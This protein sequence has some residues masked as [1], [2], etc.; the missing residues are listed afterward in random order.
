MKKSDVIQKYLMD[1]HIESI[2][3]QSINKV[4]AGLAQRQKRNRQSVDGTFPGPCGA[5]AP[6]Q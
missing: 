6:E 4:L 2:T 5:L 3:E 1:Q